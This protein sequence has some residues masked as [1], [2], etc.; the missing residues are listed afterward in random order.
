MKASILK[1]F[2]LVFAVLFVCSCAKT[3]D[4]R[5]KDEIKRKSKKT[6]V[7]ITQ[8]EKKFINQINAAGNTRKK[9]IKKVKDEA[10]LKMEKIVEALKAEMAQIDKTLKKEIEKINEGAKAEISSLTESGKQKIKGADEIVKEKIYKIE[11]I[12]A[13]NI[14]KIENLAKAKKL[15]LK[16]SAEKWIKEIE[17]AAQ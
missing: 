3:E 7:G 15:N 11:T 6:E 8:L 14:Q 13:N 5:I 1:R 10:A 4:Q 9:E 12:A 17:K 2:A 16:Q